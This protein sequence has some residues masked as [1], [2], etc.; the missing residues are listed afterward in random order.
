V[1][2]PNNTAESTFL[3]SLYKGVIEI[4]E[5]GVARIGDN[6][7]IDILIDE[8]PNK[9]H[10]FFVSAHLP[11][12]LFKNPDGFYPAL[13]EFIL[14]VPDWNFYQKIAEDATKSGIILEPAVTN[15]YY[16]IRRTGEEVLID[17]IHISG[18]RHPKLEFTD[19]PNPKDMLTIYR[20][21]SYGSV[22]CPKDPR[23]DIVDREVPFIKD[24]EDRNKYKIKGIYRQNNGKEGEHIRYYTLP[25]LTSLQRLQFILEKQSQWIVNE[26]SQNMILSP[27]L[28]TPQLIR[29]V[30]EGFTKMTEVTDIPSSP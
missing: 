16:H 21:E 19:P 22:C 15:N 2:T 5:E 24:F 28:F 26:E 13:Q 7:L 8:D 12:G 23:W 3:D 27:K 25:G 9:K 30:K 20:S 11:V 18:D 6:Y 14:V 4:K 29:I 1:H 17:S 10:V